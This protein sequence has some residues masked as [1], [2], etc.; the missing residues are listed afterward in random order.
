MRFT[1]SRIALLL[2]L[3]SVF[4]LLHATGQ[5]V[6]GQTPAATPAASPNSKQEKSASSST[7]RPQE[8]TERERRA[9]AYAKVLEGQRHLSEMRRSGSS[10]TLRLAREAFQQ[11]V[12][13]YPKLAEA[14]TALAEIAFYYPPQDFDTATR[15]GAS[16]IQL[17][18]DN[19][20]AHRIL[21]RLYTIK[22][23][24][25]EGNLNR[26]FADQAI[27]EL[28]EVVRL[29]RNNAEA[30]AL[31]GEFHHLDGRTQEAVDAWTQWSGA[32]ASTD[33]RF[34]QYITNRDLSPD[35]ALARLGEALL[36]A[37]RTADALAAIRRAIALNPDNREYI[38]LLAQAIEAGGIDDK[39]AI[40]ELQR[41]TAADPANTS[42]IEL[43]ARVQSRAGHVDEAATTL[44][45]AIDRQPK[46]NRER[47][48]LRTSLAQL[49]LD[50]L[51]YTEAVAVYEEQLKER[52]IGDAPLTADGDKLAA[53]RILQRMVEAHKKAGR[54]GEAS[55][56]IERMRRLLGKDDPT[57]DEQQVLFLR[58]Q[59][60]KSDALQAVRSARQ[61][62]PEQAGFLRLEAQMLADMGRV[63]EGVA[64]IRQSLQGSI[65]DFNDYLIIA[66]LYLQGGR[67]PAAV[68]A[69]RK[70]LELAPAGELRMSEAAL[71]TLSSA[72]ERAGDLKGSEASLRRILASDPNNATALNNLGYF[73]VERN[74]RLTEALEMI[75]RAVRSN[76]TNS[77]FLDSLG[78]AYFKLGKLDEAERH[79]KEAARRNGNSVAIHEHL[80][81]LYHQRGQMEMARAAWQK[82]LSLV[83][84]PAD[85]ARIKA[86]LNGKSPK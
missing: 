17:D 1:I 62:F 38:E 13:L 71:I 66:G 2:L 35:A 55:A 7:A 37:G 60:K 46:G 12:T 70:A 84:E 20:G 58:D 74:E 48:M 51:R 36:A 39:L 61:R 19:F 86:K 30:W 69:A 6:Y 73:L 80:G 67:A 26:P 28:K 72:Q 42:I 44:R 22:S 59:G 85:T 45:A 14:H 3:A 40:A 68:E 78:W 33:T 16:A 4:T 43:L 47:Q 31:L 34:F 15:E 77:S 76:P 29:D 65:E 32:P 5:N 8:G 79:L 54:S 25:R 75:Q 41:M 18:P 11:A 82:A 53:A 24:L 50:A 52:G 64:L 83:V 57:A 63:D 21:S 10:D 81:D 9:Q 56:T 49:Y 23:G 27:K